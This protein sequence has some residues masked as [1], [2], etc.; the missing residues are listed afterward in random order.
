MKHNKLPVRFTGQHFTIDAALIEYTI[1]L[2]EIRHG[3]LVL[4]LGGGKG[5]IAEQLLKKSQN[6]IVIEK[7]EVLT[8]YLRK[9]FQSQSS[10]KVIYKDILKYTFPDTTFKVVSNIPYSLTS[11]IFKKL[12]YSN[13]H[14]FQGG[15]IITQ[16]EPALKIVLESSY[17][18][19]SI[20]YKTFYDISL[21]KQLTPE[22]FNPPP[23]VNSALLHIKKREQH[24]VPEEFSYAYLRFLF[25]MLKQPE[26]KIQ[27]ALKKLFRKKQIRLLVE[28]YSIEL[29]I[30]ITRLSV[31]QWANCFMEMKEL[32]PTL[33]HP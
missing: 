9:K 31:K 3:D 2:A 14:N 8:N 5:A 32:V 6:L 19:Y 10:I 28:K 17:N 22:S 11:Y 7:D 12:M 30:S 24:I 25:L 33:Y 26:L 21:V 13:L 27:T 29:D 23:T 4:D 16:L 18:P 20:F 15:C 1:E